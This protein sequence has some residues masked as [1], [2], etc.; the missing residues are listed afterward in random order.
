MEVELVTEP[1]LKVGTPRR[2]FPVDPVFDYDV[3]STGGFILNKPVDPLL[4]PRV[5]V[6]KNWKALPALK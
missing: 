2:R 4:R 3:L 1:T 6:V 5:T